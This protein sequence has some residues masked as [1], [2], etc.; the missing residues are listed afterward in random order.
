V[1]RWGFHGISYEYIASALPE[2]APCAAEGKTV[3]PHMGNGSSMCALAP[4]KSVTS[5]MGF[6]AI[7]GLPMGTRCGSLDP[8]VILF[9]L[10][11]RKIDVGR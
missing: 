9:L 10:E 11:Q 8:D 3:V 5:T 1:R 7:E 2:R 4:G 6:S